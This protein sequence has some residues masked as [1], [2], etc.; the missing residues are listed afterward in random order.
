M[1]TRIENAALV[2]PD[3]CEIANLEI[4][5]GKISYIGLAHLCSHPDQIINA[6]GR[7]VLAG[8]IDIHSNG[9]AGFDLV[10]G[11]FLGD[12][13]SRAEKDYFPAM[14]QAAGAYAAT[15]VTRVLSSSMAA[16]L[17]TLQEAFRLY[18]SYRQSHQA[19]ATLK[20]IFNG[21]YI[22]GTFIKEPAFRGAHNA[23]Y[24]HEPSIELFEELQTAAQGNI[25][26]VNIP[27]EWE[28]PAWKLMR[29]LQAQGIVIA[30]GHSA[31]SGD[32]YERAIAQGLKLAVHLFNGP[33]NSSFKSFNRG[34]ALEAV[35]R[36][37]EIM[38]ELIIDGYHVDP[39]YILDAIRRKGLAAMIATTDSMFAARLKDLQTFSIFGVD[40]QVS[41]NGR[42]LQVKGRDHTLF[43]SA[44][45]MDQAF[46]NL[47]N[48]FTHDQPGVWYEKHE[49]LPLEEALVNASALCSKNPATLMGW[50]QTGSIEIGKQADL[51]IA[52]VLEMES[53]Y[54]V[55]IRNL[56]CN[57]V[58][59]LD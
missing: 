58:A 41:K 44:L 46:A 31:A 11:R 36:S 55:K 49:S 42:Y 27:P 54:E 39:A 3:S 14:E 2:L 34:A 59:L 52:D 25:R 45:S 17:A 1:K 29:H 16:P 10:N 8:F 33:T 47:L 7:Y 43:G 9:I 57:G 23:E 22:E 20:N 21:L 32:C 13:F 40:G 6:R 28:E 19:S 56:F 35:L 4:S 48:W 12:R 50:Q 30:A 38:A 24:F 51:I 5:D 26:V 37:N 53:G 18:A 15:G